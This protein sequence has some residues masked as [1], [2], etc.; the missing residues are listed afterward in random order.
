MYYLQLCKFTEEIN[1]KHKNIKKVEKMVEIT[2]RLRKL[3][4]VNAILGFYFTFLYIIIPHIYLY[5]IQWPFYDPYYSWSFG[6]IFLLFSIFI[7]YAIKQNEWEK[8]KMVFEL[9]TAWYLTIL[10]LNIF[11]LILIPVPIPSLIA[12]WIYN[13]LFISLI[14]VNMNFHKKQQ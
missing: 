2:K 9:I 10:I 11:C 4:L 7:L 12:I 3:L 1:N 8:F 5:S 6:A 13:I 14:V